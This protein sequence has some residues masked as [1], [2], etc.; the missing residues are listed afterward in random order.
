MAHFTGTQVSCY[1]Q[2]LK[3]FF[4]NLVQDKNGPNEKRRVKMDKIF[5]FATQYLRWWVR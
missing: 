3:Y 5:D 1:N 2:V 4:S